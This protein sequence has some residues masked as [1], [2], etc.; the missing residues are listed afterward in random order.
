ML[1]AID[2]MTDWLMYMAWAQIEKKN[3]K[4]GELQSG[5][6]L[7]CRGERLVRFNGFALYQNDWFC[8]KYMIPRAIQKFKRILFKKLEVFFE[9]L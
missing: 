2:S 5:G 4:N 1:L 9:Y 3:A 8:I 6:D 7:S